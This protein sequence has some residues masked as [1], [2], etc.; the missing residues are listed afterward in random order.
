MNIPSAEKFY[1]E[2]G[3]LIKTE[4]LTRKITQDDLAYQLDLTR[5]SI[6]NLEKGR[7]KPSVY[8]IIIIAKY[9][10]MDYTKLI[11]MPI[12]IPGEE[13]KKIASAD[14]SKMVSDQGEVDS[15]TKK[16][17]QDFLS[18]VNK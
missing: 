6:I 13:K 14:L 2:L 17:I 3:G 8:Q 18:A 10:N 7:H 15:S 16:T 12:N 4:R 1:E 9:F 11:P 5:A